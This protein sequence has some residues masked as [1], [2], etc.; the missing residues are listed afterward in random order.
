MAK[1]IKKIKGK[2]AFQRNAIRSQG[3]SLL[4]GAIKRMWGAFKRNAKR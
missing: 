2:N 3:S 4:G 1:K